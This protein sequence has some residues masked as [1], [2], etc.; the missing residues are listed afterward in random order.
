ME[1]IQPSY[2]IMFP[3]SHMDAVEMAKDMERIIRICYKSEA[4]ITDDSY[5]GFL[6]ARMSEKHEAM[7]EH[8]MMTVKFICDRGISHE[9]VR[10]RLAAFAQE[11]TRYCN[12]KSSGIMVICPEEIRGDD[13][14]FN[15]WLEGRHA[16]QREY[17]YYVNV[18]GFKPQIARNC[19]PTCVKTEI[20]VTA[21]WREWRH[22]FHM[23]TPLTAHP[24]MQE[25]MI[26]LLADAK[27]LIPVMFDNITV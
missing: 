12:Y 24:Q 13:E 1:I 14:A 17:E 9:L 5:E 22:I 27:N 11:S 7:F 16:D 25:L 6:R 2:K 8:S 21:N 3:Y 10:H 26:P 4:K 20:A 19:L 18:K 15:V 23:R